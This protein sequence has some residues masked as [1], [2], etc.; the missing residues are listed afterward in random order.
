[1]GDSAQHVGVQAGFQAPLLRKCRFMP[2]FHFNIGMG[3]ANIARVTRIYP[4]VRLGLGLSN[5]AYAVKLSPQEQVL[6]AF[7]F[8]TLKPPSCKAST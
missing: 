8:F 5:D 7:G 3:T 1:M 6:A 2:Y 4:S